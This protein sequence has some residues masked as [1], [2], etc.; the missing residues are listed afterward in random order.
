VS[1]APRD[2]DEPREETE[3]AAARTEPEVEGHL[4]LPPDDQDD[5]APEDEAQI[6]DRRAKEAIAPLAGAVAALRLL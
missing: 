5:D 4:Q 6:S 2:R 3:K 1:D